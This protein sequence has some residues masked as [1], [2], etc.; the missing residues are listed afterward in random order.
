MLY[1]REPSC[2]STVKD[3]EIKGA[4]SIYTQAEGNVA[5]LDEV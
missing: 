3:I 4:I 5:C 2:G 1:T